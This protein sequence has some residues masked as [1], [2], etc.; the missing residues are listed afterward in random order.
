MARFT[1][2]YWQDIPSV[3]EAVDG[4]KRHKCQLSDRFQE[5]IDACA[6][7]KGLFG[8]DA[9]LQEWHKSAPGKRDG[10]PQEVA[11]AVA[12]ELEAQYDAIASKAMDEAADARRESLRGE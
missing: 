8:T 6:M 12:G 4:R 2:L 3:V 7:R 1:I 10:S 9:Y 11:E 5:L